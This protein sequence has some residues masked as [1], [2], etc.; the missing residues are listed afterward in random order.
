MLITALLPFFLTQNTK[1]MYTISRYAHFFVSTR[2]E[3]LAYCSRSNSF[4]RLTPDLYDFLVQCKT[5]SKLIDK[6]DS[7]LNDA[8]KKHKIVVRKGDDDIY[9]LK[10]QF[11]DDATAYNTSSIGL[12]IA[13]TSA[14][15]FRCHYC[16]EKNKPNLQMNDTTIQQLITFINKHQGVNNIDITW[17]G[18]EPLLAFERLQKIYQAILTTNIPIKDHGIVTNGYLFDKNVIDYFK[19]K[20]LKSIQITLDGD[21][22][23]HDSIR[24]PIGTNDGSYNVILSNIERIL[25]ELPQTTLAIRVNIDKDNI[26]SYE[27]IF[28]EL[29]QRFNNDNLLVY[30]GFLRIDNQTG[31]ALS[32]SAIDRPEANHFDFEMIKKNVN[33]GNIYPTLSCGSGCCAT[34]INS[35]VIGPDGE[36]YK[37]WNDMGDP[38]RAI[39]HIGQ[40]QLSNP[41]LFYKYMVGSKW[42]HNSDCVKCFFLPICSSSCAYYRLRNK[43]EGGQY[44]LCQCMQKSDNLL[45]ET[46]EY[47]LYNQKK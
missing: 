18:G 43:Y 34:V 12:V 4:M 19:D 15:N 31:T 14:C 38:N 6:L 41:E 3:H 22:K 24:T 17:Y 33:S 23:R 35:Y 20:N 2:K 39:G 25:K 1:K 16:F 11:A 40:E 27:L 47:W 13:P 21:Q 30:P 7:K 45:N 37:C 44:N 29:I 26:N 5:D 28:R 8:L 36:F 46:L 32:C 42:Y 10:R 9:I